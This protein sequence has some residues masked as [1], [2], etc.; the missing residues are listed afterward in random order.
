MNPAPAEGGCNCR[1]GADQCALN[2]WCLTKYVRL[3]YMCLTSS[4]IY[5][6]GEGAQGVHRAD[7]KHLQAEAHSPQGVL[8]APEPSAPHRPLKLQHEPEIQQHPPSP[9]NLISIIHTFLLMSS[10]SWCAL[11]WVKRSSKKPISILV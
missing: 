3:T 11:N 10:S 2:G 9:P 6:S 8:Q 5:K 4:L 1:S 7:S